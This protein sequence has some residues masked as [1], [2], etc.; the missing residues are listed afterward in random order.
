MATK[1]MYSGDAI[2]DVRFLLAD[3]S[4]LV[5]ELAAAVRRAETAEQ[6]Q[7]AYEKAI[8]W[9]LVAYD[10]ESWHNTDWYKRL[11]GVRE[12]VAKRT[13][14]EEDWAAHREA[15]ASRSADEN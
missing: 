4:R 14:S 5:A 1:Q 11:R 10:G 7:Q 8:N 15:V 12:V 9:V 13:T 3:R 6:A 2:D